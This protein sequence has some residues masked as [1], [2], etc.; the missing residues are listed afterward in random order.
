MSSHFDFRE[1]CHESKLQPRQHR[2]FDLKTGT[3]NCQNRLPHNITSNNNIN[4]NN[5]TSAS[6]CLRRRVTSLLEELWADDKRV[7]GSDLAAATFQTGSTRAPVLPRPH[8]TWRCLTTRVVFTNTQ[9]WEPRGWARVDL[10]VRLS[11]V[12][13]RWRALPLPFRTRCITPANVKRSESPL[14][15]TITLKVQFSEWRDNNDEMNW[16]ESKHKCIGGF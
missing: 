6:T 14:W 16:R 11:R 15:R 8:S 9:L 3:T 13:V 4:N 2:P 7:S 1:H 12:R 5:N 10:G